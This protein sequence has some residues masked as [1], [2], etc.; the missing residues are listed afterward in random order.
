MINFKDCLSKSRYISSDSIRGDLAKDI[1][2][3]KEF[4]NSND[5]ETLI[6]YVRHKL[7]WKGHSQD[8]SEFKKM[9][10]SYVAYIN[11]N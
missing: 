10:K 5:E 8:I 3:D 4:P 6:N 11:K 9:Y 1:M 7:V 2:S